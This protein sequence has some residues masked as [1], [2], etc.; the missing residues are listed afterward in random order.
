[1]AGWMAHRACKFVF[2]GLSS[3][4]QEDEQRPQKRIK[5]WWQGAEGGNNRRQEAL[6][7]KERE[8]FPQPGGG[9]VSCV[10]DRAMGPTQLPSNPEG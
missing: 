6:D 5:A 8:T 2:N 9:G 7:V 3:E 4:E 1:M 10:D